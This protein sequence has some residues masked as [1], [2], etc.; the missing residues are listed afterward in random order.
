M[1]QSNFTKFQVYQL[2]E[3]LA[4][5]IWE[6]VIKWD[7]FAK[8]TVGEQLVRAG[9]SVPANIAE[10]AGRGSFQDNR[11]FILIARGSLY[12]TQNWLRRTYKHNLLTEKEIKSLKEIIDELLPKL[13]AYLNSLNKRIKNS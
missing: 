2:A 3:K 13:N 4:D 10:G 6:V 11:R 1:A 5:K 9:D 12:E 8:R 7:H